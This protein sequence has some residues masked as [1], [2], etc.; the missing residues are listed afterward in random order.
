MK[1][2]HYLSLVYE[3]TQRLPVASRLVDLG[4]SALSGLTRCFSG[5]WVAGAVEKCSRPSKRLILYEFEGCPFC[6]RVRETA[7]V[8]ALDLVVY[9]CPKGTLKAAGGPQTSR[10]RPEVAKLGGKEL[11]PF[12]VDENTGVQMYE[13]AEINKYLWKTYGAQAEVPWTYWL[14]EKL[15]VKP[16]IF[17]PTLLRPLVTHGLLRV[18]SVAPESPLELWGCESSP[19]VRLVREALCCLELPYVLRQ[20][21]H[22][23]LQNRAEFREKYGHLFVAEELD[24]GHSVRAHLDG[25][26]L[27]F[28]QLAKGGMVY[29]CHCD[30][31]TDRRQLMNGCWETKSEKVSTESILEDVTSIRGTFTAQRRGRVP[32]VDN[33]YIE[34][35]EMTRLVLEMGKLQETQGINAKDFQGIQAALT[36]L[37]HTKDQD[38]KAKYQTDIAM[39]IAIPFVLADPYA[40]ASV[41]ALST[42]RLLVALLASKAMAAKGIKHL[43][44]CLQLAAQWR[45][46]RYRSDMEKSVDWID[47]LLVDWMINSAKQLGFRF[48]FNLRKPC[49]EYLTMLAEQDPLVHFKVAK[50]LAELFTSF[51]SAR[52]ELTFVG[53]A[54]MAGNYENGHYSWWKDISS[55]YLPLVY[56]KVYLHKVYQE[57]PLA[58]RAPL[59]AP[60]TPPAQR[61]TSASHDAWA[62]PEAVL[63]HRKSLEVPDSLLTARISAL[64]HNFCQAATTYSRLTMSQAAAEV[65]ELLSE[66]YQGTPRL[67]HLA[68]GWL[69]LLQG[70]DSAQAKAAREDPSYKDELLRE[71]ST[72]ETF[73]LFCRHV[74]HLLLAI[75][76][77]AR[78]DD[79]LTRQAVENFCKFSCYGRHTYVYSQGILRELIRMVPVHRRPLQCISQVL[80]Q[81][82]N[83][84]DNMV[85][86]MDLRLSPVGKYPDL[87][88]LLHSMCRFGSS[89]RFVATDVVKLHRLIED[90]V[91]CKEPESKSKKMDKAPRAP[92][93]PA[94]EEGNGRSTQA[95]PE[96][97]LV[98]RSRTAR[99]TAR[100]TAR[101]TARSRERSPGSDGSATE[102]ASEADSW[103]GEARSAATPSAEMAA[104]QTEAEKK[105]PQTAPQTVLKGKEVE[106]EAGEDQSQSE[107]ASDQDRASWMSNP[108]A[109]QEKTVT[110]RTLPDPTKGVRGILESLR[111]PVFF[112][113]LL[114]RFV[115]PFD[116]QLAELSEPE[117]HAYARVLALQFCD[118]VKCSAMAPSPGIL[119]AKNTKA[120]LDAEEAVQVTTAELE[121]CYVV[122][123]HPQASWLR[124]VAGMMRLQRTR[125]GCAAGLRWLQH[126][127]LSSRVPGKQLLVRM[128]Q[129]IIYLMLKEACEDRPSETGYEIY[130]VDKKP[131]GEGSYGQVTKGTHKDT[132]AVRAIKAINRHKISD[133]AR[134]QVEVDIQSSLDH[135]NIVKL[136]EVFQDAKR[137]YLVM[138]LCTG[139]ELFERIVAESEKHDGARAFDERGAAT[140]M[141]QILGAMSYLHKNN[142]AVEGF[143]VIQCVK[144]IKPEN[145]LM[146]N[147]EA[148][149]EIKVIDFGL[150][151]N[152]VPGSGA[153]MKTRA[154]TPYYVA[155]Q[156]LAGAYDE[157]C[158]IWSCGVICYILLCGY[159]PFYG[160][161]DK[162]I[163]AMVKKGAVKFDPADWSDVSSDAIDFIK[164]MLTYDPKTRPS[165]GD[166][167]T[168]KW[169]TASATAVVGRVAKDLGHKLKR[170]QSNSRMKK[171][172]LTLIAQQLKD[173]DL[174]ELRDT[175][176]QLDK[177]R[178]GTLSLGH[179]RTDGNKSSAIPQIFG[180][181]IT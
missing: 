117:R 86:R 40:K 22:G 177:N 154:G 157:K 133:P 130:S 35:D 65:V 148:N 94:Q 38:A 25:N 24:G 104:E 128:S 96:D 59:K 135:P 107:A 142:F 30:V 108:Q 169:L 180:S 51:A 160:E 50:L 41:Q 16:L 115:D 54:L 13:S 37:L 84:T 132:G 87:S 89:P 29:D 166:L 120:R 139:G 7:S 1:V 101:S 127:V 126:V 60:D 74:Q 159:P 34:W 2:L 122:A 131:L 52:E 167:L 112:E 179:D 181:I 62:E 19:F 18:P 45:K 64:V 103:A 79:T 20:V 21:P 150:A 145:F 90:L 143:I 14:G 75:F 77:V 123:H 67:C 26:R 42:L 168:H 10:F 105:H 109:G 95:M 116:A 36:E 176:I 162:D 153:S 125:L 124:Q 4:S 93:A 11:F 106:G 144:D 172:A 155:P 113:A 136:Y 23:E 165:A 164:L 173:D 68:A 99:A 92:K 100:A 66:K 82:Q 15:F 140:Y 91:D 141:Q 69:T 43:E 174:K 73:R 33:Q 55:L 57:S 27:T 28:K 58:Q 32:F 47:Q 78:T 149:A 70:Q 46:N 121:S 161:K 3:A 147:K 81:L 83:K 98:D 163:L 76:S 175:F 5:G 44:L 110:E 114:T 88:A 72:S 178:D 71:P 39:Q 49:L 12:L 63:Q 102:V 134:F 118:V 171:V 158:D 48:D 146:Q 129:P 53:K 97:I 170:F 151:K 31:S 138:E 6:R 8:L 85:L 80:T 111:S 9:P 17:F 61:P 152:Y 156:V 137:F 56:P 119:D